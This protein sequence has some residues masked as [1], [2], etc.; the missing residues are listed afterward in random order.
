MRS[1][2]DADVK[3]YRQ[4]AWYNDVASALFS[5]NAE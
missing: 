2:Q 1:A 5:D 3:N 4:L